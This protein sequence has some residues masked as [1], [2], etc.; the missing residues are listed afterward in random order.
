MTVKGKTLPFDGCVELVSQVVDDFVVFSK[1]SAK[2]IPNKK[3]YKVA[4][5]REPSIV[6]RS[7]RMAALRNV[8]GDLPFNKFA[9]DKRRIDEEERN[10]RKNLQTWNR[11]QQFIDAQK[12][13]RMTTFARLMDPLNNI[14]TAYGTQ[15][16]YFDSYARKLHDLVTRALRVKEADQE[17][18]TPQLNYLEQLLDARYR[19]SMEDVH[20]M[21]KKTLESRILSKD[22]DLLRRGSYLDATSYEDNTPQVVVKDGDKG[23][24]QESIIN[25]IFGNNKFRRDGEKKV[26]RTITITI[27]DEVMDE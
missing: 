27:R 17:I 3:I 5:S 15:P 14:K 1:G 22:E 25:A 20:G 24:A 11:S 7:A 13:K 18:Y 4:S 19:L 6:E 9:M 16:E 21:D 26:E 23:I 2:N 8:S 10:P 12:H